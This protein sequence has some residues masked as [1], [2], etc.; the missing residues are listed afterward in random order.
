MWVVR[1]ITFLML[2]YTFNVSADLSIRYDI[3]KPGKNRPYHSILIKRDLVRINK[4]IDQTNAI[5][6]N[7]RTGDIA[8]LHNPTSRYFEINIQT[9][10]QYIGFYKQNKTLLQGL[11]DQGMT[12]LGPQQRD[13]VQ[14][15]LDQYKTNPASVKQFD[16]RV[17]KQ[18]QKVLG[19]ECSVIAVFEQGILQSEVCM[20]GYRQL[21]L[22]ADN[23]NSLELLKRFIQQFKRSAPKKHQPLFELITQ[24]DKEL[25]G[26]PM[27]LVSY[28]PDGKVAYVIQAGAISLRKIPAQAYRI[29]PGFQANNFPIF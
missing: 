28:Q 7:L 4:D 17:T 15:F 9:I 27:Q 2:Y 22:H 10:D 11:I 29:P 1:I 19:V 18:K 20:S 24:P 14:Q 5:L 26:L 21:G 8:Q 6:L 3:V 16:I 13:Q 23:I 12:Q 25:N